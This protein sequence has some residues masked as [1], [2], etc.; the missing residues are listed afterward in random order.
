MCGVEFNKGCHDEIAIGYPRGAGLTHKYVAKNDRRAAFSYFAT[1]AVYFAAL[2]LGI[3]AV[4]QGNYWIA[5]PMSLLVAAT[6]VRLYVIQHDCGH[7]SFFTT[8]KLNELAG[9]GLSLPSLSPFLTMRY[10]HDMH[11]KHVGNLDHREDGEVFTMTLR[12][13]NEAG[14]GKR[15]FYR[16]YRNPVL[17]MVAGALFTYFIRYRWPKNTSK[18]GVRGVLLHNLALALFLALIYAF[19]GWAGVIFLLVSQT[20]GGILGVFQVYLQ[21]N[22]EDTY[23]DR[24]PDLDPQVAALVGSSA[25]NLGW[26]WDLFTGNIAYH[27]IHH[28][29]PRIPLYNLRRCHFDLDEMIEMNRIGWPEA[30]AS[31]RLKLWDEDS[32]RLVPFPET[33]RVAI[34]AE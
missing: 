1:F 2:I 22:F 23:W 8:R 30:F 16:A 3:W 19:A 14:S 9:H 5:A 11:H 34:P 21:H 33:D 10:N 25:L 7:G 12:E 28:F 31:F 17:M 13:W 29:N 6:T 18:V 20:I 15:L 26:W 24:R 32:E 27:D 4:L